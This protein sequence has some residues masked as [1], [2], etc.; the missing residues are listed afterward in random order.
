MPLR[1]WTAPSRALTAPVQTMIRP[2][3]A[4]FDVNQAVKHGVKRHKVQPGSM[5]FLQR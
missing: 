4:P 3:I 1:S 2:T 5:T